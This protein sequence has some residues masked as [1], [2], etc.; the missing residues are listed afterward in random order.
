MGSRVQIVLY[1]DDAGRRIAPA[2]R[3]GDR[4]VNDGLKAG[5][6]QH[7]YIFPGR[8]RRSGVLYPIATADLA[9]AL[10]QLIVSL[11]IATAALKGSRYFESRTLR[12]LSISFYM[13]GAGVVLEG[14]SN[15]SS[16]E[17]QGPVLLAGLCVESLGYFMLA[18]S[19]FYTVRSGL[20][21]A[22]F[23]PTPALFGVDEMSW[24]ILGEG[25]ARSVAFFLLLYILIETILFFY[26]NRSGTVL[27]SIVGFLLLTVSLYARLFL[28]QF[29]LATVT[30]DLVK[31]AGFLVLAAPVSILVMR[32]R[33]AGS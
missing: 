13:I 19:H 27:L 11:V 30:I 28:F 1:V 5:R 4:R 2:V 23:L 3:I 20:I 8:L 16:P 31:L 12:Y 10:S 33:G 21:L 22:F 9:I 26:R 32:R 29:S 15:V 25:V 18:L 7:A 6:S 24:L 17:T 14:I